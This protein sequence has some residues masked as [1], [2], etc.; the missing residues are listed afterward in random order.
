MKTISGADVYWRRVVIISAYG[1][2]RY[3]RNDFNE[4]KEEKIRELKQ[5]LE[6]KA[7][8]ENFAL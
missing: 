8:R 5:M 6:A 1:E 3:C 4:S 2:A 7:K